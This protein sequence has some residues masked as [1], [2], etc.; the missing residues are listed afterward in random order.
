MSEPPRLSN[1]TTFAIDFLVKKPLFEAEDRAVYLA[2]QKSLGREVALKILAPEL[3]ADDTART[4]FQEEAKS[5]GKVKTA[6][7]LDV[8]GVGIDE[9]TGFPWIV[10]E[11]L[12]GENLEQRL[13]REPQFPLKDWDEVLAQVLHGLA[14]VH[15]TGG[16]HGGLHGESIFLAQPGDESQPFR[17]ELLDFGLPHSAQMKAVSSMKRLAWTAPEQL[18]GAS[19]SAATDVW[20]VGLMAYQLLTG[21]P[22]FK[23]TERAALEEEI[24]KGVV[25]PASERAKTLGANLP[26]S[27][28]RWFKKCLDPSINLRFQNAKEALEGATDLLSE[29]SGVASEVEESDEAPKQR[30]KPP[31]LPP[32]VRVITENPKPAIAIITILVLAALGGGFGLGILR[33]EKKLKSGPAAAR[34]A[35]A[36]WSKE[37]VEDCQ[38]ACDKGDATACHGLGQKYQYGTKVAKD[39]AMAMQYFELACNKNDAT[40]CAS[41]AQAAFNGEGIRHRPDLAVQLFQKACDLGDAISCTDLADIYSSGNEIPKNETVANELRAKACKAGMT[42]VCK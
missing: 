28:D 26:N 7:V 19:P 4:R 6:H 36:A 10:T 1:G 24:H 14:A 37:S 13:Q 21:K 32:M 20:A 38:K 15:E 42:E 27:F 30:A 31:P 5:S 11:F 8:R 29:A 23:A 41:A 2:E 22:Y 16:V 9:T 34:A 3:L 25:E 17:I 12:E 18:Q 33:G 40:A 39:S 35:A